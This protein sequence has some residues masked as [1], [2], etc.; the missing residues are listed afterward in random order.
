MPPLHVIHPAGF[1]FLVI[2]IVL[3]SFPVSLMFRS[4]ILAAKSLKQLSKLLS[5]ALPCLPHMSQVKFTWGTAESTA[6][7]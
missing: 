1:F 3:S 5:H 7:V 2:A 6:N 4:F